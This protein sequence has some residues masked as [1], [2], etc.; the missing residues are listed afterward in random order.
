MCACAVLWALWA[1]TPDWVLQSLSITYYPDRYWTLA[2]PMY[3]LSLVGYF[4]VIYNAW[5]LC[6]TNPFESYYTFRGAFCATCRV[7]RCSWG[8]RVAGRL[9]KGQPPGSG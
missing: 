9:P 3:G 7:G 8:C 5:N 2:L 6:N 4:I 1:Y